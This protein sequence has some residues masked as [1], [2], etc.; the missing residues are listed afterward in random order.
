MNIRGDM[1]KHLSSFLKDESGQ[2]TTEY[3]LLLVFVVI[4][5]RA[6]GRTLTGKLE[7]LVNIVFGKAEEAA[8]ELD[9][10]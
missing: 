4:A 2:S 1:K 5:V 7:S 3:V 9:T 10:N 6:V 8:S